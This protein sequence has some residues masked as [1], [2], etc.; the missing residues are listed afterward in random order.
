MFAIQL[1]ISV[2]V[3]DC[4][5]DVPFTKKRKHSMDVIQSVENLN[6]IALGTAAGSILIYS[7]KNAELFTQMV[8]LLIV[9]LY[10]Y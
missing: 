2:H 8:R 7:L 4:L 5:Q 1:Q 10:I 9:L 3:C 6:L